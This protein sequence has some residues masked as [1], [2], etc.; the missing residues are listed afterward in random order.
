MNKVHSCP[1]PE[2]NVPGGVVMGTIAMLCGLASAEI[3]KYFA[4]MGD[5]LQYYS[6]DTMTRQSVSRFLRS[7]NYLK[8][9]R[10][11]PACS[12]INREEVS[13]DIGKL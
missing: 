3:M 4:G 2:P 12:R 9:D 7:N 8:P 11:C 5:L 13:I 6:F 1:K 10:N